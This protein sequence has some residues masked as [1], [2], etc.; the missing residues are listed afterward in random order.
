MTNVNILQVVKHYVLRITSYILQVLTCLGSD[1]S[2]YYAS[3]ESLYFANYEELYITSDK[4]LNLAS[5]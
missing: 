2:S 1:E 5:D 3:G 4:N